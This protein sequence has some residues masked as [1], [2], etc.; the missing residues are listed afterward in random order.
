MYFRFANGL[1]EKIAKGTDSPRPWQGALPGNCNISWA[2]EPGTPRRPPVSLRATVPGFFRGC[3][4]WMSSVEEGAVYSKIRQEK[5]SHSTPQSSPE[6]FADSVMK[7][8][9][10]LQV[11]AFL[12]LHLHYF[13]VVATNTV[14][15]I[16]NSQWLWTPVAQLFGMQCP[17]R[18]SGRVRGHGSHCDEMNLAAAFTTDPNDF[19][20]EKNL[21]TILE[22]V[23]QHWVRSISS[24]LFLDSIK[25]SIK[26]K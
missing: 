3:I 20:E 23:K 26:P 25:L 12:T 15:Y 10:L 22:T 8:H 1:V 14:S 11:L 9:P 16:C 5:L 7:L 18:P 2:F 4:L 13:G 21:D 19:R 24:W 17:V 6:R